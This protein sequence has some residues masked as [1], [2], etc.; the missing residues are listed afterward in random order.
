LV[1]VRVLLGVLAE[2]RI[3]PAWSLA[4]DDEVD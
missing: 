2:R 4:F 1:E 3:E